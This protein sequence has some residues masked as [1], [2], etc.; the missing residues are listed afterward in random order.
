M[1]ELNIGGLYISKLY[2]YPIKSCA[3][4]AVNTMPLDTQGAANDR[5][6]M[7]VD[8]SGQFITQRQYSRLV[9]VNVE[10]HQQGW[11]IT[12]PDIGV[13]IL[14]LHGVVNQSIR[15]KVWSDTFD[16]YDQGDEWADFFSSFLGKKVRLVFSHS[17]TERRID[18]HY[19]KTARP[20]SFADGFPLLLT[21]ESSLAVLN[22]RLE[23]PVDMLR[24]RPN[25][26]VKGA[27]AFAENAWETLHAPHI[28]LSV[29]KPC[30]RCV[31]P[32][33]NPHT[34]KKEPAVWQALEAFCKGDDGKVYFGQNVIHKSTGILTVGDAL[35]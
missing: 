19:C 12:L 22:E 17:N 10:A 1:N 26:V 31:I 33:I 30:S 24:F 27:A 14:P 20:V 2:I 18:P 5:R 9:F 7:L 11:L 3:A 21:N 29:V 6:Y 13:K 35:L 32:T 16:A 34:A 23:N 25:I 8:E 15:V 28:Q 4:I